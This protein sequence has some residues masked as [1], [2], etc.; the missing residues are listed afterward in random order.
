MHLADHGAHVHAL[1]Q[2]I[3]HRRCCG[4]AARD[5]HGL[6]MQG[7]RHEHARGGVAAL[8]RIH[9]HRLHALG[10]GLLQVGVVQHDVGR[11]A[12]QFLGHTLDA[13]GCGLGHGNARARGAREGHHV[14]AGVGGHGLA[15]TGAVAVDEVEDAGRHAR[16][17]KHLGHEQGIERGDLRGLEHHGAACG[18]G[19][20][21]LAHDLV[22]GP[23][24]GRDHADHAHGLVHDGRA[25]L[26]MFEGKVLEDLDGGAQMGH[27]HGGLRRLG[28]PQR[29]PHLL[30]D[31]LHKVAVAALVDLQHLGQQGQALFAA[32]ARVALERATRGGHS[33]VH[34]GGRSHADAG[35]GL[36]V[37][38][39]DDLQAARADRI[40]PLAVDIELQMV[41]HEAI[42]L[43][44][45]QK[46]RF[47]I[48]GRRCVARA[49][50]RSG[51]PA[52]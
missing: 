13:V 37:G 20:G 26:H 38:G 6:P 41:L 47:A 51:A 43:V 36:L 40:H 29:R 52:W 31:G 46:K 17:V 50:R 22:D 44:S 27:T 18:Q 12:A 42:S 11:L 5:L 2:R 15:H 7:A 16:L 49:H 24:P 25:A 10:H 33:L 28:Q 32:G 30:R 45:S 48:R 14:Y 39:I 8:A 35:N 34:I 3:G 9:Q 21:N 19:R 1:G 23:V 4:D